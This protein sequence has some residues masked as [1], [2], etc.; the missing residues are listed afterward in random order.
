MNGVVDV[1]ERRHCVTNI[2]QRIFTCF[3][4]SIDGWFLVLVLDLLLLFHIYIYSFGDFTKYLFA[5]EKLH[6]EPYI[7]LWIPADFIMA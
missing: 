5:S 2:F 6:K 1:E 4:L 7:G 3:F